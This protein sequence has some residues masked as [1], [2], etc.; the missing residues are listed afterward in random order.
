MPPKIDKK[1]TAA[2]Q[3]YYDTLADFAKQY[4]LHEGAVSVALRSQQ[5]RLERLEGA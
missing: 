3:A 1:R 4:A 5:D 2:L